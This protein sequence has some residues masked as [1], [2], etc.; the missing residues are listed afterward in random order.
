MV[1]MFLLKRVVIFMR[2]RVSDFERELHKYTRIMIVY[3]YNDKLKN[4]DI[5]TERQ[6]KRKRKKVSRK[7]I[8]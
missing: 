4:K 1:K 6:R 2:I 3:T 8:S 7:K 5:F